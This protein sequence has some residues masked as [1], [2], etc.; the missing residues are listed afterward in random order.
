MRLPVCRLLR[1]V[2]GALLLCVLS[3]GGGRAA[4]A[5]SPVE[6]LGDESAYL[7]LGAGAFDVVP[8]RDSRSPEGQLQLRF[9]SKLFFIGPAIGVLANTRGGLFGYGGIYSDIRFFDHVVVTPLIGAGAYRRGDGEDLGGVFQFRLSM[10]LSYEF[11]NGSRFGAQ[12]AHISNA[13]LHAR[14]PSEDEVLLTYAI[15]LALW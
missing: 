6:I 2:A 7:E 9:G 5:Q 13:S 4:M 1:G 12:F 10:N 3:Q 15:P 8:P 11:S 14:N